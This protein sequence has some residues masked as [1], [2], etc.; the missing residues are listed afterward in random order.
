MD[1]E[2][3]VG[4]LCDLIA[5]KGKK[6]KTNSKKMFL[7]HKYSLINFHFLFMYLYSYL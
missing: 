1:N 6:K 7:N 3:K 2:Y 4:A 5:S